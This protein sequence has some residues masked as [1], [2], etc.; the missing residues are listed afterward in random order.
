M[1]RFQQ[2]TTVSAP[3]EKAYQY[4]AD[5]AKHTEWASHLASAEKTSDSAVAVGST[6]ATLGK[7]L[8]THR[9]QVTITELVP[10]EKITFES[11]DDTGHFRHDFV[12]AAKDG[13][14]EITKGFEPLRTNFPLKLASPL[15]PLLAPRGL[16]A[17]LR[18]IKE[19]LE[20]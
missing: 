7:Q 2:A 1:A 14:T 17:D 18:K 9:A 15:L 12:F 16:A 19:R 5:I 11:E 3:P 10:N 8:G 6:F 13:G 20:A 4:L